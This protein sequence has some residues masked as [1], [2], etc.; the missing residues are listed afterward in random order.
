M[1]PAVANGLRAAIATLVPFFLAGP[2]GRAELGWM[3]LGGWLGTLADPGGLKATR[4]RALAVFVVLGALLVP[5]AER[6]ASSV[7]S[8]TAL[9][10]LVAFA[11]TLARALGPAAASVGTMLA[12]VAAVG[13][14]KTGAPSFTADAVAFAAGGAW[15]TVL[16]SIACGRGRAAAR[17]RS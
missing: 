8:A 17:S 9:L 5:L 13:T 12:V 2:L 6:S 3:A 16:S 10:A 4:A 7:G 14:A 11:G 15:A 1:K